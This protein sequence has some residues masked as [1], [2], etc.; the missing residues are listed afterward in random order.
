MMSGVRPIGLA[1]SSQESALLDADPDR[2]PV[3]GQDD[4]REDGEPVAEG[5]TSA[6]QGQ[7]E[8]GVR[9]M[10]DP[11]VR[12]AVDHGLPGGHP[13]TK[14]VKNRPRTQTAHWRSAIPAHISAMLQP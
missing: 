9:R 11:A 14:T 12:S 6:V 7:Q 8:T 1:E 10:P 5:H 2:K 3:R 13:R 4:Q